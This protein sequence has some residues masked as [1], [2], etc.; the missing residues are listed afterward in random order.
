[1]PFPTTPVIII[2]YQKIIKAI[3]DWKKK[4]LIQNFCPGVEKK[5]KGGSCVKRTNCSKKKLEYTFCRQTFQK[6]VVE[7]K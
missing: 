5:K 4:D 7:K 3:N 6:P 2:L 1:M